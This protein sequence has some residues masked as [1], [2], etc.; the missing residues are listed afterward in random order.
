MKKKTFSIYALLTAFIVLLSI[1]A[2]G[3]GMM[4]AKNGPP[5][6]GD[7]PGSAMRPDSGH[8]PLEKGFYY[9]YMTS[10]P[11]ASIEDDE[12]EGSIQLSLNGLEHTGN[13]VKSTIDPEDLSWEVTETDET[14]GKAIMYQTNAEWKGEN[15]ESKGTSAIMMKF[16]YK[17]EG[18]KKSIDVD[19]EVED[20]PGEGALDID[21]G[22]LSEG[23]NQQCSV[24]KQV[25]KMNGYRYQYQSSSGEDLGEII[26]DEEADVEV[27]GV[28][29][30]VDT[31]VDVTSTTSGETIS[32]SSSLTQDVGSYSV[33]GS[34]VIFDELLEAISEVGEN[35]VSYVKDHIVSF[36]IG[37]SFL[38]IAFVA[39]VAF[40]SKKGKETG[41][42]DLKLMNNRYYRK[43]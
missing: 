39:A 40:L 3:Q 32:I 7:D 37:L 15:G 42:E 5:G 30:Q 6:D 18:D 11:S 41:G 31:A 33:S 16:T 8:G 9:R 36:T 22:I 34:L 27:G 2:F 43:P 19:I 21:L 17:W 23:L 35:A 13:G 26:I 12:G 38:I 25:Q 29:E 14:D 1:P 24:N 28:E 20:T 4:D 10:N